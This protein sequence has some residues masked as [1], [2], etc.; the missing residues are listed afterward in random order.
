MRNTSGLPFILNCHNY[1][2][3]QGRYSK[4]ITANDFPAWFVKVLY[5]RHP[6]YLSAKR[7]VSLLYQQNYVFNHMF[8]DD[9]LYISYDKPIVPVP[10][11]QSVYRCEG[12][13][14]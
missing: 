10:R 11:E 12:F 7:V 4:K 13:D 6:G 1:L 3:S 8:K 9:F 5:Y 14:E 2:F